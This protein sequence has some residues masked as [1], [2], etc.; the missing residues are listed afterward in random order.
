VA[1][2]WRA[3]TNTT[4]LLVLLGAS[5]ACTSGS[6]PEASPSSVLPS[7]SGSSF[8]ARSP[9]LPGAS[10]TPVLPAPTSTPAPSLTASPSPDP[11]ESPAPSPSPAE[12]VSA[13]LPHQA[14]DLEALLPTS[15]AGR[16]MARG[17][18]RGLQAFSFAGFATEED[19]YAIERIAGAHGRSIDDFELATA[20]HGDADAAPPYYVN[21]YRLRGLQGR[22]LP[23]TTGLDFPDLGTW[24]T[25]VLGGHKLFVGD[26]T[27]F[28]QAAESHLRPYVWNDGPVHWLIVTDDDAWAAEV[29]AGLG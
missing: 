22:D 15:V 13:D 14:P 29:L 23:R 16:A 3:A 27:M 12:T 2:R 28:D 8:D 26:A 10:V 24:R 5:G 25:D 7:D 21:A 6:P 9:G 1:D 19:Y 11:P 18:V 4:I 17:S 20:G